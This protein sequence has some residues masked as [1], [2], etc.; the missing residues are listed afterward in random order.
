MDETETKQKAISGYGMDE[1][2]TKQ[3]ITSPKERSVKY[4]YYNLKESIEFVK[5]VYE[6]AGRSSV[7]IE[8]L[9]SHLKLSTTTASFTYNV[10][11]ATQFGLIIKN[12]DDISLTDKAK[13]IIVPSPEIKVENILKELVQL[14]TLYEKLIHQYEDTQLPPTESLANVLY[15]LGIAGNAKDRAAQIFV[16]SAQYSGVLTQDGKITIRSTPIHQDVQIISKSTP[17]HEQ[18]EKDVLKNNEEH[19]HTYPEKIEIIE[20]ISTNSQHNLSIVLSNNRYAKLVIPNDITTM[21]VE[22]LKK[23]LDSLV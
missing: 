23:M 7:S 14:P 22:K 13:Q 4:P 9:A 20:P 19:E 17:I 8:L 5:K 1:T 10:S 21:E 6:V 18:E 2:E 16:E 3:K 15:H 12:K 11:T